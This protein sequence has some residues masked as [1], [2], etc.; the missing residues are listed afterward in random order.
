MKDCSKYLKKM[1]FGAFLY[2]LLIFNMSLG[3]NFVLKIIISILLFI[4]SMSYVLPYF[5]CIGDNFR[6]KKFIEK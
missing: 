4:V 6:R 5:Q 1:Y 3:F 2:L